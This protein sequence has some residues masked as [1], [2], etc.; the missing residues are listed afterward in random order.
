MTEKI[1]VNSDER[2]C[3]VTLECEEGSFTGIATC[4]EGDRFD[5]DLGLA[6]AYKRALLQVKRAD[7]KVFQKETKEY[8]DQIEAFINIFRGYAKAER[9]LKRA[10]Q[11]Q[12]SLYREID[13]LTKCQKA[14]PQEVE[15]QEVE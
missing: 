11:C 5:F 3:R 7:I 6:L 4:S 14:K 8:A 9:K 2:V 12:A 15:P 10:K 13:A 1:Y